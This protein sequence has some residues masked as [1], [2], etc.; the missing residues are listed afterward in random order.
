M[1]VIVNADPASKESMMKRRHS[2]LMAANMNASGGGGARSSGGSTA[3]RA[4]TASSGARMT[5]ARM[6]ASRIAPGG[7]GMS[8]RGILAAGRDPRSSVGMRGAAGVVRGTSTTGTGT[9]RVPR[10]SFEPQPRTNASTTSVENC[11]NGGRGT[12]VNFHGNINQGGEARD[13]EEQDVLEQEYDIDEQEAYIQEQMMQYQQRNQGGIQMMEYDQQRNGGRHNTS[14]SMVMPA[15]NSGTG[16][17]VPSLA[18]RLEAGGSSSSSA[19]RNGPPPQQN[20]RDLPEHSVRT[21]VSAAHV[22]DP[23][24]PGNEPVHLRGSTDNGLEQV[25]REANVHAVLT[26]HRQNQY[27]GAT[28]PS[29]SK[30][31]HVAGD[32]GLA[33]NNGIEIRVSDVDR[34]QS[35]VNTSHSPGS[36]PPMQNYPSPPGSTARGSDSGP[37]QFGRYPSANYLHEPPPSANANA[38]LSRY[39]SHY[40]GYLP[41]D[42]P[43]RVKAGGF[44]SGPH[45]TTTALSPE[46]P[47]VTP[48]TQ[49]NP[50]FSSS[51]PGA[52]SGG[53]HPHGVRTIRVPKPTSATAEGQKSLKAYIRDKNELLQEVVDLRF[54]NEELSRQIAYILRDKH[55]SHEHWTKASGDAVFFRQKAEQSEHALQIRERELA[56]VQALQA[57]T[58]RRLEKME[59]DSRHL[60]LQNLKFAEEMRNVERN[61]DATER[62]AELQKDK[63]GLEELYQT[64]EAE[65]QKLKGELEKAEDKLHTADRA[66]RNLV[67]K[68]RLLEKEKTRLNKEALVRQEDFRE[69]EGLYQSK[70]STYSTQL[71]AKQAQ[72]DHVQLEF[73]N[74][75]RR[76]S[77]YIIRS[78]R[79][80]S[81]PAVTLRT[82][83]DM[84]FVEEKFPIV[85]GGEKCS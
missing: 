74:F 28:P 67:E 49:H 66:S 36:S 35:T 46:H 2:A 59:E 31:H 21:A 41:P 52:A 22:A 9:A 57:E 71:Q 27:D 82:I 54:V 6:T 51:S 55:E 64:A 26:N 78:R 72:L 30:N 79:V 53:L 60:E 43:S 5:G 45:Y 50:P 19:P 84:C 40:S 48:L 39:V 3:G 23:S 18:R 38:M 10:G 68:V 47:Y 83:E 14:A 61:N 73:E 85:G 32:D 7:A 75:K 8:S 69:M 76:L 81:A 15:G 70:D 44:G 65:R 11:F 12:S 25:T 56:G 16:V 1:D 24:S 80:Q 29:A 42:H 20:T 77:D 33:S 58:K 37:Q 62:V 17:A 13:Q 4:S 34:M 63:L